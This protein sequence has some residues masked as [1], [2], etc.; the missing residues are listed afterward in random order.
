MTSLKITYDDLAV[1]SLQGS[2]KTS[3]I[4]GPVMLVKASNSVQKPPEISLLKQTQTDRRNTKLHQSQRR[5]HEWRTK[6]EEQMMPVQLRMFHR[7][8]AYNIYFKYL[9]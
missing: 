7:Y 1:C 2:N 6:Q 8:A 4:S 5:Q 9:Y 3:V